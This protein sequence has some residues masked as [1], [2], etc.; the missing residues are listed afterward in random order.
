MSYTLTIIVSKI[1]FFFRIENFFFH[2]VIFE[3]NQFNKLSSLGFTVGFFFS[4]ILMVQLFNCFM[5]FNIFFN[6]LKIS[7]TG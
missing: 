5:I 2:G 1:R 4:K 6:I 7:S 3:I